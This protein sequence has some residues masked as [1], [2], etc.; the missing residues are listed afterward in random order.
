MAGRG[1]Q[2]FNKRLKEQQRKEKQQEKVTKRV[3]RQSAEPVNENLEPEDV[4]PFNPPGLSF[5]QL[6]SDGTPVLSGPAAHVRSL[7]ESLI[8][9]EEKQH[10][11]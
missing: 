8:E 2:S 4:D 5:E 1:R 7:S 9:E 11:G 6:N 3:Q 10:Q